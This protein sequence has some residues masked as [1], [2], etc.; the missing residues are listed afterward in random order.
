MPDSILW[1]QSW[2]STTGSQLL[3]LYKQNK[4]PQVIG[5]NAGTGS[6]ADILAEHLAKVLVCTNQS[7][8]GECAVCLQIEQGIT[9]NLAVLVAPGIDEIRA[10]RHNYDCT[11]GKNRFL[12]IKDLAQISLQASNALLKFIEEPPANLYIIVV[13]RK[14]QLLSTIASRLTFFNL[15]LGAS[16]GFFADS[17]LS[18]TDFDVEAARAELKSGKPS[19]QTIFYWLY[20]RALKGDTKAPEMYFKVLSWQSRGLGPSLVYEALQEAI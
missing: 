4:L 3:A 14:E 13:A 2:L 8:C 12:I 9:D 17:P 18:A 15:D 1:P 20:H 11:H 5:L 19:M 10:I 6:G 7:A 16:S